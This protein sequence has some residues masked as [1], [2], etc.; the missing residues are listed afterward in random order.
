MEFVTESRVGFGC[1]MRYYRWPDTDHL[2]W[3]RW[4]WRSAAARERR[5]L[6]VGWTTPIGLLV[7]LVGWVR[8]ARRGRRAAR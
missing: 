7:G 1:A 6:V 3:E 8:A 4:E 2:Y 5:S